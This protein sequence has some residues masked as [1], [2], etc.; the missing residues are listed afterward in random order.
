MP[1]MKVVHAKD[2]RGVSPDTLD[3]EYMTKVA[4]LALARAIARV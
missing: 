1:S 3:Y 2:S 4:M